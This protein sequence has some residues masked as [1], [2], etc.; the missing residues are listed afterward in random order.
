MA[1][2]GPRV[3]G[4]KWL[5]RNR[6]MPPLSSTCRRTHDRTVRPQPYGAGLRSAQGAPFDS[7]TAP[8]G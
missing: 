1:Q 6:G 8:L 4:Q 2:E 3:L 5:M 7:W